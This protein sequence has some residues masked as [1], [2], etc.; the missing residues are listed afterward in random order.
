MPRHGDKIRPQR[1]KIHRQ[2]PGGLG[3]V[4]DKRHPPFPAHLRQLLH[5]QNIAEHIGNVG[6]HRRIRPLLQLPPEAGKGVLPV[7][8]PPPRH[9]DI[10][11]QRVK[12][13]CHGVMLKSGH[14]HP[15]SRLHDGADG[16]VQSVGAAGG[17]RDLL[18][19]AV[20]QR[21]GGFPA[22]VYRL[23]GFHCRA[24][25]APPRIRAGVHCSLHRPV[26]PRRL[27]EGGGAVVQIDHT[28]SSSR[29]PSGRWA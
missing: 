17:Q 11:S 20:K 18:R 25:S 22:G 12:G 4:D 6:E 15:S 1:L 10:R 29:F 13:A 24:I 9:P 14:D 16:D 26:H 8:Q 5:G 7:K 27:A 2:R 23:R 21:S 3:G 28:V 19:P